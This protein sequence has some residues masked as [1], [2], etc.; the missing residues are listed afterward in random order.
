MK[1]YISNSVLSIPSYFNI[2][3]KIVPILFLFLEIKKQIQIIL[4]FSK[5]PSFCSGQSEIFKSCL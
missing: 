1:K 4:H 2:I 3:G 5:D